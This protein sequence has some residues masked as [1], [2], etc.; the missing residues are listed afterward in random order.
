MAHKSDGQYSLLSVS[1]VDDPVVTHPKLEEAGEEPT[2]RL[3]P[4]GVKILGK[5][6]KFLE[7]TISRNLIEVVKV[8]GR[9]RA[10]L[11]SVHL[12]FQAPTAGHFS[13]RN[14]LAFFLRF[15]EIPQEAFPNFWPQ[16]EA[17]V[18]VK[19]NLPEL[20]LNYFADKCLQ[21]LD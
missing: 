13:G 19:Q 12:P 15:R 21:L 2:Q 5:P 8:L 20:F 3:G 17:R 9:S 16:S 14:I 1:L 10:K 7:Q 4:N 6:A 11:D 18:R